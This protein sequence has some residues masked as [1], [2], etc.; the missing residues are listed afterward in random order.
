MIGGASVGRQCRPW[1][2]RRNIDDLED[3]P[4]DVQRREIVSAA[5]GR[6][7]SGNSGD[8][9]ITLLSKFCDKSGFGLV[10]GS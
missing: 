10:N 6:C 7:P 1:V 8:F 3:N 9:F 4:G 5:I 2:P